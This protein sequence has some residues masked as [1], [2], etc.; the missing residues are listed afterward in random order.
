MKKLVLF[1][2]SLLMGVCAFAGNPFGSDTTY[3]WIVKAKPAL[4][5]NGIKQIGS[6]SVLID[7]TR[8]FCF[9][10]VDDAMYRKQPIV[11][12][13][14][15]FYDE[16]RLKAETEI[17]TKF[18]DEANDEVPKRLHLT[19][20]PKRLSRYVLKLYVDNVDPDGETYLYAMLFDTASKELVYQKFYS[21]NGG[22]VGSLVNLMGDAAKRLGKKI[23]KDISRQVK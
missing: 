3:L 15:E 6:L 10:Y 8:L 21:A 1:T 12:V 23:G 19:G 22:S 18:I 16:V 4:M 13:R 5:G 17:C 2:F 7:E 11:D 14:D 20:N 9:Y